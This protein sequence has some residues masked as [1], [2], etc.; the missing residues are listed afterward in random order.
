M[1]LMTGI[2][3]ADAATKKSEGKF[4]TDY[5]KDLNANALKGARI[6]IA[7][8]FMGADPDVD[9]VVEASLDAPQPDLRP[10]LS[11]VAKIDAGYRPLAWLLF[12]R[13]ADWLRL[14][15]WTLGP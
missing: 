9:W 8:D 2:D 1:R 6:G 3:S 13:A 5:T 14:A 12:H 15:V 7:R 11:G 10:G 4:L